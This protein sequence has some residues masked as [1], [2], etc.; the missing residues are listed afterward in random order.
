VRKAKEKKVDQEPQLT[1]KDALNEEVL[2]QLKTAQKELEKQ[3][4]IKKKAEAER[5]SQERKKRENHKSFEEL[6]NES[7]LDWKDFK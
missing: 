4:E 6:L 3:E 5:K 1:L 7:R 2:K